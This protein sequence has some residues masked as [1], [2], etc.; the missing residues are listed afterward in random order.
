MATKA[1]RRRYDVPTRRGRQAVGCV[2]DEPRL[3]R[4]CEDQG[5]LQVGLLLR[6]STTARF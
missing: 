4:Q 5:E 3:R 1:L 2:V 6:G